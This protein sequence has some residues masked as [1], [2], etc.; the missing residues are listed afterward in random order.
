[1]TGLAEVRN[2]AEVQLTSPETA[3]PRA[4]RFWDRMARRYAKSPIADEAAYQEKLRVTRTYFTPETEVLEFG[5]GTGGTAINH[6]PFVKRILATDVSAEMITICRENLAPTSVDNVTFRR[7]TLDDLGPSDGPFD[8]VMGMSILHLLEDR[9]GAIARVR[10]LLKPGG[11]FV[12]ST[13][14]LS[15]SARLKRLVLPVGHALGV[16]PYVAMLTEERLKA[17]IEAGGFAIEHAWRP[18]KNKAVFIVARKTD[19]PAVTAG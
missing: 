5:C 18:A 1:M 6:A 19:E 17:D 9:T 2:Q 10:E 16:L 14:C 13:I 4:A 3:T 8:V 12:S 15:D 7:A 11:V